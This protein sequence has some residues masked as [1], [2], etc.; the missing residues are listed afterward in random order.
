MVRDASSRSSTSS[1]SAPSRTWDRSGPD[2][3][4]PYGRPWS[5]PRA[6]APSYQVP[7]ER[8]D[9]AV[10]HLSH[11]LIGEDEGFHYDALHDKEVTGRWLRAIADDAVYDGLQIPPRTRIH[12][13]PLD[14]PS[15]VVGAEQ[16]NTSLIFGD[17]LI[18]KVPQGLPDSIRTSRCTA[19]SPRRQ[20]GRRAAARLAG[21]N[22][23]GA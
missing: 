11:A 17:A 14:E 6:T 16:S 8:R 5:T 22:L 21:G 15:I 7:V 3:R 13:V 1:A 19:R 12:A 23:A 18:L 10:D 9:H 2:L 4:L 20:R